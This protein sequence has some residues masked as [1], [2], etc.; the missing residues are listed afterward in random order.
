[1]PP[2]KKKKTRRRDNAISLTNMAE[3]LML[4][5][6][7]TKAAFNMGVW[8]WVSDGWTSGSSGRAYG[9][10]QISLH[11]LIY[12]NYATSGMTAIAGG[13]YG[14]VGGSTTALSSTSNVDVAMSN[15]QNNWGPALVKSILI[16]VGFKVGRRALSRPIRMGN[17][18]LKQAGLR[19]VVKI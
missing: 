7:G 1:M 17:K 19:S 2:R 9:P 10:G 15:L 12:G 8:N 14:S 4:A 5:D 18:L 11:E 16:P 6:V 3:A 13:G